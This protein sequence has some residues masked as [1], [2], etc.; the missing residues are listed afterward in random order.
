MSD[1]NI[2]KYHDIKLLTIIYFDVF[3]VSQVVQDF[4]QQN[5][6]IGSFSWKDWRFLP[7]YAP[8]KQQHSPCFLKDLSLKGDNL[9]DG[10]SISKF[11]HEVELVGTHGGRCFPPPKKKNDSLSK[12]EPM[13]QLPQNLVDTLAPAHGSAENLEVPPSL[14][15]HL[16]ILGPWNLMPGTQ[17]RMAGTQSHRAWRWTDDFPEFNLGDFQVPTVNSL[18][19]HTY[20]P[21]LFTHQ[22]HLFNI[23][24]SSL[25]GVSGESGGAGELE[26]KPSWRGKKI[27]AWDTRKIAPAKCGVYKR[28]AGLNQNHCV[29]YMRGCTYI[30][31]YLCVCVKI[32]DLYRCA[33][34][35]GNDVTSIYKIFCWRY[36]SPLTAASLNKKLNYIHFLDFW[37]AASKDQGKFW[38]W[39]LPFRPSWGLDTIFGNISSFC[40]AYPW[41]TM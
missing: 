37:D 26:R 14:Q 23:N 28:N 20:I 18:G 4:H 7:C 1:V 15:N 3:W 11:V 31:I 39:S 27:L 32:Y 19:V 10:S 41:K 22:K 33:S 36:R 9:Q 6:H 40:G 5:D 17:N 38:K 21:P 29:Y 30:Y 25:L 16:E 13:N 34:L 2:C 12:E 8:S 35:F 24:Q